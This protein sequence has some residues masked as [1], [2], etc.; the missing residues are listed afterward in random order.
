[1]SSLREV[2]RAEF[3]FCAPVVNRLGFFYSHSRCLER[4]WIADPPHSGG[5]VEP[6]K[7]GTPQDPYEVGSIELDHVGGIGSSFLKRFK[8]LRAGD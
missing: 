2:R 4:F 1:M 7:Q 8:R 5:A 3:P 6:M